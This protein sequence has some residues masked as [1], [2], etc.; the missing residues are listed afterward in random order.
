[1]NIPVPPA[2]LRVA[3][4]RLREHAH[5]VPETQTEALALADEYDRKASND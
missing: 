3:A 2:L 5:R 4:A 1:M